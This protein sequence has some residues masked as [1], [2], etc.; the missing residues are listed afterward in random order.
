MPKHY[1]DIRFPPLTTLC[2]TWSTLPWNAPVERDLAPYRH[3]RYAYCGTLQER[4]RVKCANC[5]AS[6]DE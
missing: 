4:G 3:W 5:G 1:D 2:P 6:R